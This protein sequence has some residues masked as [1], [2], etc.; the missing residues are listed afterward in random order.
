MARHDHLRFEMGAE[1][2]NW[3]SLVLLGWGSEQ[4]GVAKGVPAHGRGV[5]TR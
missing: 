3:V 5:E 4:P 1:G 2:Y